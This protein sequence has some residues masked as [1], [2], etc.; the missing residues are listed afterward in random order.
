M[1]GLHRVDGH[2]T[3]TSVA[4]RPAVAVEADS[5]LRQATTIHMQPE[6]MAAAHHSALRQVVDALACQ[7]GRAC[8]EVLHTYSIGAPGV[9]RAFGQLL[10]HGV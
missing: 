9:A 7:A 3:P 6:S 8:A 1:T 2:H 10:Q 5:K 4:I